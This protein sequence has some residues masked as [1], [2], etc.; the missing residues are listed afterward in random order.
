MY[1][2][3]GVGTE[4]CMQIQTLKYQGGSTQSQQSLTAAQTIISISSIL[5]PTQLLQ[6][7]VSTFFS[8]SSAPSALSNT[9]GAQMPVTHNLANTTI[10]MQ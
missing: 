8:F 5:A 1:P 10:W 2:L 9:C 7:A 4:L 3:R 6:L